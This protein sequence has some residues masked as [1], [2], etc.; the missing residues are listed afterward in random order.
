MLGKNELLRLSIYQLERVFQIVTAWRHRVK[1]YWVPHL[2]ILPIK[3]F[4]Y[5]SKTCAAILPTTAYILKLVP[6]PVRKMIE[7]NVIVALCSD[8]NPNGEI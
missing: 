3:I 5:K 8:Y 7:A 6:P 2:F 1:K 4:T